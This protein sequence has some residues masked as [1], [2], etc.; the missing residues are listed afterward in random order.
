MLLA[1]SASY[2]SVLRTGAVSTPIARQ[3]LGKLLDGKI[4]FTPKSGERMYEF[5]GRASFGRILG[6]VGIDDVTEG[7]VPVR[8]FEPRFDG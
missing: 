6:I 5:S 4:T 8:G 3:V 2:A 1:S 7:M